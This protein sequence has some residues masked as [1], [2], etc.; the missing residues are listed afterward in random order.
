MTETEYRVQTATRQQQDFFAGYTPLTPTTDRIASPEF[1]PYTF[2]A[3]PETTTSYFQPAVTTEEPTYT[4]EPAF[5]Y[6]K[7]YTFDTSTYQTSQTMATP[8]IERKTEIV[9]KEETQTRVYA[10]AKLNARGKIAVAVYSI[11]VAII[12]ALCIYNAIAINS[13]GGDIT[14]KEGIVATQSQIVA[15][16]QNTY[17][18]LGSSETII[19]STV[20]EFKTPTDADFVKVDGFEMSIRTEAENP[21]NWFEELCESIRKLFF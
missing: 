17:E 18:A 3:E 12:V 1:K 6:Q 20:G 16:L 10:K 11:V 8:S 9:A 2:D 7:N 21:T 5:E 15:E 13:L 14:Y 4:S 19:E